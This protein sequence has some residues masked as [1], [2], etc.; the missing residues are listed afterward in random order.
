MRINQHVPHFARHNPRAPFAQM[1]ARLAAF[2]M[3]RPGVVFTQ[4]ARPV[5]AHELGPDAFALNYHTCF[6]RR[7]NL[8]LKLG[9]MP[10]FLYAD[11]SGFSGWS[12]IAGRAFDPSA[13]D[14]ERAEHFLASR[15]EGRILARG[16]TKE[17][18]RRSGAVRDLPQGYTFFPL[19]V[20][21]DVVLRLADLSTEQIL[22]V[23]T[24]RAA[25]D[26]L[27]IKLHPATQEP[28]FV[29]RIRD[30]HDP[31]R[32]VHVVDDHIH[33]LILGAD[34]VV[35]INSG[36]GFEALMLGRPVISCGASDYH[37]LTTR[38]RSAAELEAALDAR[39]VAPDRQ[40]RASYAFWFLGQMVDLSS[41]GWEGQIFDRL[42]ASVSAP[43]APVGTEWRAQKDSNPQ[44]RT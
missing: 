25:H 24:E 13:V 31:R 22:S 20:P 18:Q 21:K 17:A 23:L 33:D 28:D 34:R 8:N 10:G 36:T 42:C 38:V 32:G 9:Y 16:V 11:R 41:S 15:I 40:T 19:Q 6:A 1:H 5:R 4:S 7:R 3:A 29:A 30:L 26:P 14:A 39:P 35:T 43:V 12:E 27:V 44:P 37:H 2:L